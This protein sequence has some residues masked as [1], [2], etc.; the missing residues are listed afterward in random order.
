M[1]GGPGGSMAAMLD[2]D[3]SSQPVMD[4]GMAAPMPGVGM[5]ATQ[6]AGLSEGVPMMQ[7]SAVL[8]EAP[9]TSWQ[10]T[11]LAVC[12]VLLMLCGM[13]MYD[14]LRN[15]WSWDGAYALNSSL[16]DM[17]VGLFEGK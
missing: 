14:M 2:E 5:L 11:G 8:S 13:M 15:M 12:T 6:P 1:M 4:L 10:I 3:L 17:I 16:M 9:Y 7:S